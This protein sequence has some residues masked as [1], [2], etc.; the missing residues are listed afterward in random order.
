MGYC[1][2]VRRSF[3]NLNQH[4]RLLSLTAPLSTLRALGTTHRGSTTQ[5]DSVDRIGNPWSL[6]RDAS[7]GTM[8]L[9]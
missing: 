6:F 1:L 8:K 9:V 3:A 2:L 5:W 7:L 4:D